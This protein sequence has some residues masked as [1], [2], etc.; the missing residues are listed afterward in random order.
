[1]SHASFL[2][3]A[4]GGLLIG[5]SVATLWIVNGRTAGISGIL[6][7]VLELDREELPW[8]GTFLAGLALGGF[9]L[10]RLAPALFAWEAPASLG[11]LTGA[12]LLVGFGTRLGG[13]C[14]SGHGLCGVSRLSPRSLVATATFMALGMVSV[15]VVR[16][17][18]GSHA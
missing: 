18:L 7:G 13:G 5:L 2:L 12:G 17:A 11:M 15:Y 3:P 4:I 14:T 16:H 1:M 8:R 6:G 10:G 9:A